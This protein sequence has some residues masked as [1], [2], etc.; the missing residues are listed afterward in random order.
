MYI[1]SFEYSARRA[2]YF[3]YILYLWGPWGVASLP[4]EASF[5]REVD[6]SYICAAYVTGNE[7]ENDCSH[8][9]TCSAYRTV[10]KHEVSAC[11]EWAN[12]PVFHD[13]VRRVADGCTYSSRD[14]VDVVRGATQGI[15]YHQSL[16]QF[17]SILSCPPLTRSSSNAVAHPATAG[18]RLRSMFGPGSG[19][20]EAVCHTMGGCNSLHKC[21]IELDPDRIVND[22]FTRDYELQNIH[23]G[24]LRARVA[25]KLDTMTDEEFKRAES[26]II[27]ARQNPNDRRAIS[28]YDNVK[29][30][31]LQQR[32]LDASHTE[33]AEP[34]IQLGDGTEHGQGAYDETDDDPRLY[35]GATNEHVPYNETGNE[36]NDPSFP[37]GHNPNMYASQNSYMQLPLPHTPVT[38]QQHLAFAYDTPFIVGTSSAIA[39]V[40]LCGLLRRLT[41]S[42][43]KKTH[44]A[45]DATEVSRRTEVPAAAAEGK[46]IVASGNLLTAVMNVGE[47]IAVTDTIRSAAEAAGAAEVAAAVAVEAASEPEP[48]AEPAVA[49]ESESLR[50]ETERLHVAAEATAATAA[51]AQGETLRAA[52]ETA[53]ESL[54]AAPVSVSATSNITLAEWTLRTAITR[55]KINAYN[56]SR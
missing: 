15:T 5:S 16:L 29:I 52:A 1:Y 2:P 35:S 33:V 26:M 42:G 18:M 48:A 4:P 8:D 21:M 51:A 36:Y 56:K 6:G 10:Y 54:R 55:E 25:G 53:A 44:G 40:G 38:S 47:H 11:M 13:I 31:Q 50:A 19:G 24:M 34:I 41:T 49:A 14:L 23:N 20:P 28:D 7:A 27:H 9:A 22:E 37:V 45:Q 39:V 3:I 12:D 46:A 32:V 17:R 43:R 30:C